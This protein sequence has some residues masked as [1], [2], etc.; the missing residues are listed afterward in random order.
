MKMIRRNLKSLTLTLTMLGALVL[1]PLSAQASQK[2][3][4]FKAA[5]A[6]VTA[7]KIEDAAR[8]F[9]D[10]AKADPSY[11]NG[12]AQQQCNIYRNIVAGENARNEERFTDGVNFFNQGLLE[13]ARNKFR[14]IKTGVH[15]A[16]AQ[17][18][19]NVKIPAAEQAAAAQGAESAMN[20]KFEQGVQAFSNNA[21]SSAQNLFSQVTGGSHQAEAQSYVQKIQQYTQLMQQGDSARSSSQY[22][23]ALTAYQQAASIKS[24]G[25]GDPS[26]KMSVVRDLMKAANVTPPPPVQPPPQQAKPAPVL[27]ATKK[28]DVNKLL[29]DAHN[30]EKRGDVGAARGKYLAILS[31]DPN[32]ADARAGFDAL[33]KDNNQKA[34]SEADAM[35]ARGLREFYSGKYEDAEVHIG[36]YIDVNG[37]K[38]ALAYF[39]RGVSELTRYFLHGQQPSD[40]KLMLSAQEDFKKA[41][42]SSNFKPPADMVSPKIMKLYDQ[43]S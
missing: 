26:G 1:L 21:F 29:R 32:N 40:H 27:E 10:V 30:A 35:L 13:Q 17:N 23:A 14:A 41:K 37:G 22:Q 42:Q 15:L 11:H 33:P 6:A 2:D 36:D 39:Y 4:D 31:Q 28:L 43:A 3:D 18:Y 25:P 8:L 16:E 5:Q 34:G 19:L 38:S 20:A 9:C 12:E 24:D 7:G